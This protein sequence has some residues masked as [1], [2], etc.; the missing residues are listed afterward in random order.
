MAEAFDGA[1]FLDIDGVLLD[2]WPRFL[3]LHDDL[4]RD[5][6]E[7][8]ADPEEFMRLKRERA[9]LTELTGL[10]RDAS[11]EYLRRWKLLAEAPAYLALDRWLP[12]G[13]TALSLLNARFTVV[14]AALRRKPAHLREQLKALQAPAVAQVL[15]AAPRAQP[16][17]TKARLIQS[18]PHFSRNA[19]VIGDTEVDIRAGKE[20]G[21]T[22]IGVRGGLRSD[23]LLARESP[24]LT[25]EGAAE[26]PSA[27]RALFAGGRP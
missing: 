24:D 13:H 20:L 2:P 6:G 4:L 27:L 17:E 3:K 22:T 16:W 25:L 15:A 1:V 18:S 19:V 10:S 5:L 11:R 21:V 14:L 26:L 8:P 23:E 12:Q 9:P 7:G